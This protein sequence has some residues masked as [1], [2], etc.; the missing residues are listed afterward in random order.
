MDEATAQSILFAQDPGESSGD[1]NYLYPTWPLASGVIT[2][3]QMKALLPYVSGSG[4]IFR[5]Q[6]VGYSDEPGAYARAE[7]VIDA[8]GDAPV[9]LSWRDLTHLGPGFSLETLA[10]Q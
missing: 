1:L 4:S 3:E 2:L 10:T 8:S 9:V 7:V 6:I 5:A